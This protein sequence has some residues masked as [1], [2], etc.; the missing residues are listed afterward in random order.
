MEWEGAQ[1]IEYIIVLPFGLRSAP[2]IFNA[3]VDALQWII[4]SQGIKRVF[5]YLDGYIIV[6][7][8]GS[9]E[10][11]VGFRLLMETYAICGTYSTRE[12]GVEA[13]GG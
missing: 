2:K 12:N 5:H 10:C 11:E 3:M 7:E 9:S 8:P 1:F 4:R 6:G 13:C